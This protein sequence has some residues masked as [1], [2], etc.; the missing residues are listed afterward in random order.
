VEK[1]RSYFFVCTILLAIGIGLGAIG[2]HALSGHPAITVKQ[3]ESWKTGVFYQLIQSLGMLLVIVIGHQ[4]KIES[5]KGVLKLM[6]VGVLL[7]SVSIYLL[8]LNAIWQIEMIKYA[9]IPLTPIGG[10][11]MIFGWVWLAFLLKRK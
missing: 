9:M 11:L 6:L 3:I 10:L 5:L 8:V 7:F 4:F 2:A 1:Y